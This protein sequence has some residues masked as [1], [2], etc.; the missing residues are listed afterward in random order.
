VKLPRRTFL[1]L[2]TAAAALPMAPHI[3]LT[4]AYPSRPV[5]IVVGFAPGGGADIVARLIGQW[6]SERLGQPFVVE[7]RPGAATNIAIDAVVRSAPDGYTI[8]AVT[9]TNAINATLY[10]NLNFDFARDITPIGSITS[11]PNVMAVHPSLP[12]STVQEFIAYAKANPGKVNYGSAGTGAPSHLA[13]ELFNMLAGVNIQHI[14][15][16]G[17]APALTDLLGGQVQV[18]FSPMPSLI[19]YVRAGKLR[20]LAVTTATRSNA[21]PDVPVL[22]DTLP[23]Y[24]AS[25]WYG[26]GAPTNMPAAIVD[27]LNREI[28]ASLADSKM[29]EKLADLGG[30]ALGGSAADFGTF[31]AGEIDKWGKV[32]RAASIKPE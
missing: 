12:A 14:P 30:T 15:Y 9:S 2:A 24:E 16:R 31:V 21:M 3:A 7:N 23:G 18:A 32:I 1:R 19:E 8:A 26:L 27:R 25:T 29:K 28:N 5:R 22:A 20:A 11:V 6:M 17:A 13:G 10:N 4:Q